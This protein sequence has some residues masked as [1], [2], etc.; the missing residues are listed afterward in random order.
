ML[1]PLAKLQQLQASS[2]GPTTLR[3]APSNEFCTGWQIA[4]QNLAC[5]STWLSIQHWLLHWSWWTCHRHAVGIAEDQTPDLGCLKIDNQFKK[6]L[7]A[8]CPV[9]GKGQPA[10]NNKINR[11][12]P[13]GCPGFQ[14]WWHSHAQHKLLSQHLCHVHSSF[15]FLSSTKC[16]FK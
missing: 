10:V 8:Q 11:L 3:G 9:A 15:I 7:K 12:L 16:N 5:P 6:E 14:I 2:I 13:K 4:M 1:I